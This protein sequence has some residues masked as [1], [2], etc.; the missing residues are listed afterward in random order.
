MDYNIKDFVDL[1]TTL[2]S[3]INDTDDL[4]WVPHISFTYVGDGSI[5]VEYAGVTMFDSDEY[6]DKEA[7]GI[8]FAEIES[9]IRTEIADFIESNSKIKIAAP[10]RLRVPEYE[11]PV[12][13]GWTRFYFEGNL[14]FGFIN[15]KADW[16]K[17]KTAY[18][19]S[20]DEDTLLKVR[21]LGADPSRAQFGSYREY[22]GNKTLEEFAKEHNLDLS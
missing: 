16:E 20:G 21:N 13:E 1:V 10:G 2:Q 11:E 7:E 19:G 6:A 18:K 15:S 14:Y 9:I 5:T 3:E 8:D 12:E 22:D 17:V 4:S